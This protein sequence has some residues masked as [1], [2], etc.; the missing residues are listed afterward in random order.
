[1]KKQYINAINF[2]SVK[3]LSQGTCEVGTSTEKTV[4]VR[5]VPLNT[6]PLTC[7]PATDG[8]A[9]D[10]SL[11]DNAVTKTVSFSPRNDTDDTQNLIFGTEAGFEGSYTRY[12]LTP[13]AVDANV[14]DE[15]GN[16]VQKVQGFN[17][18]VCNHSAIIT[19]IEVFSENEAQRA[20]RF[21]KVTLDLNADLCTVKGRIPVSDTQVNAVI[22]NGVQRFTDRNGLSYPLLGRIAGVPR[23]QEIQF[24]ILAEATVELFPNA[25]ENK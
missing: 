8:N 6:N 10:L 21:T 17:A 16:H 24:T 20:Q 4:L 14:S 1:M 3:G 12:G 25:D 18:L 13:S 19:K 2:V 5:E 9:I 7:P 11:L 23:E 15:F 22:I